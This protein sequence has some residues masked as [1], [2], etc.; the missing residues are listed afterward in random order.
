MTAVETKVVVFSEG[1]EVEDPDAV[2]ADLAAGDTT[3]ILPVSQGGTGVETLSAAITAMLPAQTGH[4]GKALSTNGSGTLSWLAILTNPMAAIGS[5]IYGGAS[6]VATALTGNATTTRKFL[7]QTGDGS[8]AT[9]PAWDTLAAGDLPATLTQVHDF[10]SGLKLANG[11][12]LSSYIESGSIT[13]SI[14]IGGASP[15]GAYNGSQVGRYT[16]IGNVVFWSIAFTWQAPGSIVATGNVGFSLSGAPTPQN[17]SGMEW[18][19]KIGRIEGFN[20]SGVSNAED[21]RALVSANSTLVSLLIGKNTSSFAVNVTHAQCAA[22][23][24]HPVTL[25]GFYFV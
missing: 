24:Y 6:G 9:P 2:V 19:V 3:G 1:L 25:S 12:T 13:P 8:A 5:L 15:G 22:G 7:Q 20:V 4:S 23:G 17:L 11:S 21:Y 14:L 18:G 10:S 16:R